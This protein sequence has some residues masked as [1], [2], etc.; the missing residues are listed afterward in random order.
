L[1]DRDLTIDDFAVWQLAADDDGDEAPAIA[2]DESLM[3]G[4]AAPPELI[5]TSTV[6]GD[7]VGYRG[8]NLNQQLTTAL[9]IADA[10]TG[11]TRPLYKVQGYCREPVLSGDRKLAAASVW[12]N[13]KGQ[14]Y[15][16]NTRTGRGWNISNNEFSDRSPSFSPDR[17][18]VAFLS[19]RDGRWQVYI[20]NADGGALRRLSDSA[21]RHRSPSFSPD[22]TRIAFLSD[23]AGD[24]NVYTVNRDGG[25]LR[26][27]APQRGANAYDPVWSPDGQWLCWSIQSRQLRRLV[28]ARADGSEHRDLATGAQAGPLRFEHGAPTDITSLRFSPDGAMLAGAFTDYRTSGIFVVDVATGSIRKLVDA[29]PL[30]PYP[31]DWYSTGAANPRWVLKTFTGVCFSPDGRF[32]VYCTNHHLGAERIDQGLPTRH[33][34]ALYALPVPDLSGSGQPEGTINLYVPG[35]RT[36]TSGESEAVML[37]GTATTWPAATCWWA[38][39]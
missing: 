37:P 34:F 17:G 5:F 10:E 33:G 32:L 4:Y 2:N 38:P 20:M 31:L 21:S 16:F 30:M 12:V 11:K 18:S 8:Q 24:F 9:S 27:L 28:L 35:D 3:E 14:I 39:E 36:E 19:D 25:D 23:R 15:L 26:V 7:E 29:K 6:Y 13:G 1:V 22:G